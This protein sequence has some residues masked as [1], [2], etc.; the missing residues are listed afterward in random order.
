MRELSNL[1]SGEARYRANSASHFSSSIGGRE[2]VIGRHSV[3]LR[4]D[5]VNRVRP[6][7]TTRPKT[8]AALLNNQYATGLEL[9]SGKN[10]FFE[11]AFEPDV[12]MVLPRL[13]N[14]EEAWL[15]A[16]PAE[17]LCRMAF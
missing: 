15:G 11:A 10:D 8:L 1:N 12:P 2:P 14:G 7:K 17:E 4:P 13:P 16:A 6:P 5:S 3:I 9:V